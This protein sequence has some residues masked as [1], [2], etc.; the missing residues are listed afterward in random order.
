MW[1]L[2]ISAVFGNF[3]VLLTRITEKTTN[4][5]AAKQTLFIANLAVSDCLMGIYMLILASA[6][7]YYGD[8]Y[9]LYS[10]QWRSGS[11]CKVASFLGLLS[12]EASVFFITTISIDRFISLLFPFSRFL[13]RSMASRVIVFILWALALVLAIIPTIFAG[14]E[15]DLYDLS[16][17]CIGLPLIT[18]PT[19]FQIESNSFVTGASRESG[20]AFDVPVPNDSKPAWYFSIAIFLGLNLVCFLII[21]ICYIAIF[22]Y[23][24]VSRKQVNRSPKVDEEIKI[25]LKMAAVVGTDFICWFPVII[26]GILSQTGLAVIP[27]EMYTWSVVFILPVNS[28]INPYLY[29]LASVLADYRKRIKHENGTASMTDLT[30]KHGKQNFDSR[31]TELSNFQSQ[32]D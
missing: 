12:S 22:W 5:I 26:M 24:R 1:I 30:K 9:F 3:V 8:Q 4:N 27:L 2:G 13:I 18:R 32:M 15:S 7:L 14:P 28:S 11:V 19:S 10:D 23:I 16:D 25:A 20:K 6:D 31:A 17:V 29:T 21:M